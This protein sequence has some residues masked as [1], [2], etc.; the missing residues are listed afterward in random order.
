VPSS[1]SGFSLFILFCVHSVDF[2]AV[3]DSG[4]GNI[5][6]KSTIAE[7]EDEKKHSIVETTSICK[8]YFM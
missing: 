5:K 6:K 4:L 2:V 1:C 3:I 7:R 8:L